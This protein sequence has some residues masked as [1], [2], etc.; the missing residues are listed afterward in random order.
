MVGQVRQGDPAFC[1]RANCSR[2]PPAWANDPIRRKARSLSKLA[3]VPWVRPT[4][5]GA[6]ADQSVTP[7][8]TMSGIAP[9]GIRWPCRRF[10]SSMP[11]PALDRAHAAP[12]GSDFFWVIVVH[13]R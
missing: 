6:H 13:A 7:P 3:S 1:A 10:A 9:T 2:V 5:P 11:T 4:I 8:V 12:T